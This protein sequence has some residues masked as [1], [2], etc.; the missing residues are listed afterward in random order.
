L[1]GHFFAV[2][3]LVVPLWLI[4]FL[5]LILLIL[6]IKALYR[7][8]RG[9]NEADAREIHPRVENPAAGEGTFITTPVE[10]HFENML[11]IAKAGCPQADRIRFYQCEGDLLIKRGEVG[12]LPVEKPSFIR[13]GE[14]LLGW[15]AKEKRTVSIANLHRTGYADET[16]PT[17]VLSLLTVPILEKDSLYGLL[18]AE[19]PVAQS[20]SI[21]EEEL[22]QQIAGEML[23]LLRDDLERQQMKQ[24]AQVYA[25]L[26]EISKNLASR[27][28]LS[29]RLS[30][31]A[32]S[33]RAIIAYDGCFIF[34]VDAE[35]RQMTVKTVVGYDAVLLEHTFPLTDGLISL[36]VRNRQPLLFSDAEKKR[37]KFF[38]DTCRIEIFPRSFLGLP[39]VI[40]ERVIGAV[41]FT[42]DRE[43]AFSSYDRHVL[44]IMC[45]QVATSIAQ[46]QIHAQ[47]SQLAITDG[48]TGLL[49]HRRFFDRLAEE[50]VRSARHPE[51]FSLLLIDIDHFKQVNDGHGHPAGDAVLKM[52][53]ETLMKQVRKIDVVAR[54]GGEEFAI[55]LPR[56]DAN[57]ALLTAE[58]IRRAV[59]AISLPWQ[60]K[61]IRA[62]ISIG[63]AEHPNDATDGAAL[64]AS[65]DHALYGSKQEGRNRTTLYQAMPKTQ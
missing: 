44:S 63:I 35:E 4:F 24:Q 6:N 49:N 30:S 11:R 2:S 10:A 25:T 46:A 8:W 45:N 28:D 15:I 29:H 9:S 14:G 21:R 26:L 22:L 33:A 59:E 64:I 50:F 54:Y 58:R 55:L 52:V 51:P 38:P 23:V 36:I 7:K 42:S 56:S 19:S 39:L 3:P 47:V 32:A 65:A 20:F 5:L 62:T 34:L 57:Q 43:N 17:S 1:N 60:N 40:E 13:P 16:L 18:C 37:R 48:L 41:V 53:S 12:S 27:L 31:T 61:V